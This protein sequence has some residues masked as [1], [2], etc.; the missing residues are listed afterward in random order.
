MCAY[1]SDLETTYI[2]NNSDAET[3]AHITLTCQFGTER[4]SIEPPHYHQTT[5]EDLSMLYHGGLMWLSFLP[6]QWFDEALRLA[7]YPLNECRVMEASFRSDKR[8][9]CVQRCAFRLLYQH[10][11]EEFR[12]AIRYCVLNTSSS[13]DKK[14]SEGPVDQLLKDKG[15]GV[16]E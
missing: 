13:S 5:Q 2:D 3:V 1:F 8:G 10:D 9:L 14:T 7:P 11:E 16:M 6:R 15:K 4:G 12:Q